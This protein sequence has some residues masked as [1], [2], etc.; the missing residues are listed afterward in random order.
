MKDEL[1]DR[2]LI[3]VQVEGEWRI[4]VE[5]VRR[6]V[7]A[8]LVHQGAPPVEVAVVISDD[9]SLQALNRRFRE[10]NAPTDVLAFPN[11]ARGP[12]VGLGGQPRYLGDVIMSYP[13]AEAQ[14][15][16]AGHATEAELQL[17]AVHGILHL[18]GYDDQ[19]PAARVEMWSVQEAVLTALG[20][21]VNLPD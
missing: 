1:T 9:E 12:F 7:L 17:L 2:Y 15:M 21:S 3:D 16:G 14:A 19:E 11:E 20:V 5:A 10:I 8:T 18:L 4:D 6:A 13:R